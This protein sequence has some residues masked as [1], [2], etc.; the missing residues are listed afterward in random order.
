MG[1][2][3]LVIDDDPVVHKLLEHAFKEDD[4]EVA[5]CMNAEEA[6]DYL[7][8]HKEVQAIILDWEMPGMTGLE[9]LKHIKQ[10]DKYKE[11]PVIMLTGRNK[12]EEIKMGI[13]AGAYYY[14]TK[15]FAKEILLSVLR[16]AIAEYQVIKQLE[17]QVAEAKNPF[18]NLYKGT[19]R[20]KTIQDA[21]KLSVLIAN[22][23]P[24]PQEN[25]MICELFNNAIE[26]G[27]LNISYDEKSELIDRNELRS[28][29]ERRLEDVRY[30]DREARVDFKRMDTA[31]KVTIEDMGDGFDYNKYLTFDENRVFDNHGRGIAMANTLLNI[32]YFGKGNKV[33]VTIPLSTNP[34]E[35]NSFCF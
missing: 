27:N 19:F 25:L 23:T 17:E 32:K 4:Y 34:G 11:I 7:A 22:A 3:V 30:K 20:I 24:A 12:R 31:L 1:D 13:D 33:S 29:I 6:Q 16:S 10:I 5:S 28:E 14:V 21:Q 15:P 35:R 8:D 9:F 26:H 2:L 18:A